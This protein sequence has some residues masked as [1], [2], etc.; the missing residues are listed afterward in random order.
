MRSDALLLFLCAI[1]SPKTA[2][3][4]GPQRRVPVQPREARSMLVEGRLLSSSPFHLLLSHPSPRPLIPNTHRPSG[5]FVSLLKMWPRRLAM[6]IFPKQ[7]LGNDPSIIRPRISLPL[8]RCSGRNST[9]S[10]R[11]CAIFTL[12][13]MC[14]EKFPLHPTHRCS[15]EL[16]HKFLFAFRH[17]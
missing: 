9:T 10:G 2:H 8:Q 15:I 11:L 13:L 12:Q 14:H 17:L 1:R 5:G 6:M 16:V 3:E 4:L 7:T